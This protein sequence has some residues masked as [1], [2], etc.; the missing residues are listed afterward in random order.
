MER[1]IAATETLQLTRTAE[2]LG[3]FSFNL[4]FEQFNALC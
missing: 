4:K 1:L 3:F 2:I